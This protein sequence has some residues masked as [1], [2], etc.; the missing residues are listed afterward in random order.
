MCSLLAKGDRN[1]ATFV[2]SGHAIHEHRV[3][4]P[5]VEETIEDVKKTIEEAHARGETK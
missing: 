2:I 4:V 1:D 3:G 5:S